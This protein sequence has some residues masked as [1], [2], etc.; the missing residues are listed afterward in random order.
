MSKQNE[1]IE[2]LAGKFGN[3]RWEFKTLRDIGF[4][5]EIVE[6]GSVFARARVFRQ[7]AW[8]ALRRA[9]S[10]MGARAKGLLSV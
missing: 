3:D 1:E 9:R 10:D 5:G 2:R 8:P 6:I 7:C 4:W